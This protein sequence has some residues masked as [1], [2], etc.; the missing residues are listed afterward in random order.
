MTTVVI[1]YG[2]LR[3]TGHPLYEA[4]AR[5]SDQPRRTYYVVIP[6]CA[7]LIGGVASNLLF[8]PLALTGYLVGGIGDAA[9]EPVGT[10]WGK[11]R[12]Q[13]SWLGQYG[14]SKSVEGSAGILVASMLV[15]L[16]LTLVKLQP[17]FGWHSFLAVVLIAL[18]VTLVEAVSPRGWDNTPM[19]IIPTFLAF[20]L[21]RF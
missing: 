16:G 1:G 10:R 13:I 8:G 20:L 17:H 2:L 9:G 11:H 21:L 6:Y 15:L 3:G 19:Q 14:G 18:S 5:E 12:Y 4:I 7:T